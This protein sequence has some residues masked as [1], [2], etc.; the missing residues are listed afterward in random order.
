MPEIQADRRICAYCQYFRSAILEKEVAPEQDWGMCVIHSSKNAE[1]FS[2][3]ASI[4][5][6]NHAKMEENQV[7]GPHM[8]KYWTK[9]VTTSL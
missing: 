6:K 2:P 9:S 7:E 3:N 5:Q 4:L 1:L 8:C